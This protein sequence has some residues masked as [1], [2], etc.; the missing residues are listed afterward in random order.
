[1]LLSLISRRV[2]LRYGDLGAENV[3]GVS[4]DKRPVERTP[5]TGKGGVGGSEKWKINKDGFAN[6]MTEKPC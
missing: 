6:V 4:P 3:V 2:V 5:F 1:M